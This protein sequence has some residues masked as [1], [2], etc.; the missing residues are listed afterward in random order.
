MESIVEEVPSND[1]F[2]LFNGKC[3]NEIEDPAWKFPFK[4]DHFQKE[5]NYRTSIGENVL[6]TAHTGSG[7]TVAAIYAI[8]HYLRLNKKVIYTAPIKSLSNQKYA[9]LKKKFPDVGIMTGDIKENPNAQCVI[10]TT[11]ILRNILFKGKQSASTISVQEI[12]CVIFDEIHYINDKGRGKVWEETVVMLPKKIAIV[13]LSATIDK[14]AELA[15]WIGKLKEKNTV[16]IPTS[17]RVVPLT[18]VFWKD[19]KLVEI[20][21][22]KC[23]FKNYNVINEK[24]YSKSFDQIGNNFVNYLNENNKLPA[25]F[26]KFSRVACEKLVYKIRGQLI[27]HEEGA[28]INKVFNKHMH[29]YKKTYEYLQQ[30]QD[31]HSL[32]RKGIAYHHSGLIPILKEIIEILYSKGLIKVL[33]ATE[34]FAVGVNMPAKTVVFTELSKYDNNGHRSLT[35]AEYL[36]MAGRAGRR[37][38]DKTGLVC[39]LPTFQL[40]THSEMKSMMTGKSAPISSK[41]M[42]TYQFIL[43]ALNHKNVDID[44]FLKNTLYYQESTANIKEIKAYVD[45]MIK[46]HDA[47][48]YDKSYKEDMDEYYE[49]Q[50]KLNNRMFK[51]K[52]KQLTKYKNKIRILDDNKNFVENYKIYNNKCKIAEKINYELSRINYLKNFVKDDVIIMLKI[53]VDDGY[54]KN[55]KLTKKGIIATEINEC[56]ELVFTEIVMSGMFDELNRE[57]IVAV[58]AVFIDENNKSKEERYVTELNI[59]K[60]VIYALKTVEKYSEY[61]SQIESKYKLY[62]NSDYRMK[63]GFVE[64]AYTWAK[65]C[66]IGDIY[67]I[68]DIYEGNFVKGIMRI[69]NVCED[70]KNIA[71]ILENHELLKKLE[72]IEEI[73]IRDIVS[74]NS[75]YL[76][77]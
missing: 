16:L 63:L 65:G 19:N 34:T 14:A 77:M 47:I 32:I 7:K 33:F 40:P 38:L 17:H 23:N 29:K 72:S 31:I 26:F 69:N 57:E 52:K 60:K 9:E 41:F 27:N 3:E 30:Y 75:L 43:K 5:A 36:Q 58:L 55:N 37:G 68:C 61:F 2:T 59:P 70:L 51:V 39:L 62:I 8:A 64:V 15:K 35:T 50:N 76:E 56:H 71:E 6:I 4:L 13:G 18:H 67:Q 25:I 66:H 1:Y 42:P 44:D 45:E 73:L 46:K 74:V 21:D 11:E 22:E 10:M 48:K 12:G 28:E 20:V 54:V 49:I 24:Y 53:L